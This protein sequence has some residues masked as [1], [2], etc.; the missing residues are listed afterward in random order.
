MR[1]IGFVPGLAL[2]ALT[3]TSLVN[4]L[5]IPRAKAPLITRFVAR[6]VRGFYGTL[7]ARVD[8]YERRDNIWAFAPPTYLLALSD[9]LADPAGGGFCAADLAVRGRHLQRGIARSRV[10]R[11]HAGLRCAARHHADG[12]G[13]RGRGERTGGGRAADRLPAVA[14][15]GVQ[16]ARNPRHLAGDAGRG[17]GVGPG[18]PGPLP[19]DRHDG[20]P[21]PALRTMD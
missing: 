18:D 9:G 6:S 10:V 19:A 12:A 3:A 4:S 14:V 11:L 16:P 21:R 2:L 13:L 15:F 5:L 17:A 20:A 8:D 1:W 7:T